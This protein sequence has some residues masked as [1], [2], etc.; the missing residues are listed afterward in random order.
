M[1]AIFQAHIPSVV[2]TWNALAD[3]FV[4]V[5]TH[6]RTDT[7]ARARTHTH[8]Y[9]TTC[10]LIIA[11]PRGLRF[12]RMEMRTVLEQ[13]GELVLIGEGRV[14]IQTLVWIPWGR[15]GCRSSAT[16]SGP[17][18][19]HVIRSRTRGKT[20]FHPLGERHREAQRGTERHRDAE[21]HTHAEAVTGTLIHTSELSSFAASNTCSGEE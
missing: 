15:G 9:V 5:S 18:N 17:T 16:N 2:V 4:R 11:V 3:I 7:R 13:C 6:T 10:S 19:V 21:K 14:V 12:L 8:T 20:S 1:Q